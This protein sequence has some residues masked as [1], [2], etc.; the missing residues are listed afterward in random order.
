[1]AKILLKIVFLI[2]ILFNL[3]NSSHVS[4]E[5]SVQTCF[6]PDNRPAVCV[7]PRLCSSFQISNKD[8]SVDSLANCSEAGKVCCPIDDGTEYRDAFIVPRWEWT[9]WFGNWSRPPVTQT[10][11][12][13]YKPVVVNQNVTSSSPDYQTPGPNVTS[14]TGSSGTGTTNQPGKFSKIKIT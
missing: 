2:Q 11:K 6:T 4:H 3:L 14:G 7:E 8:F 13:T 12:P 9:D 1:M 5:H 10:P